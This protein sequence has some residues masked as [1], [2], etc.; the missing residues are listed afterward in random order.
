MKRYIYLIVIML[1][2]LGALHAG[3]HDNAGSYGYKFLNIPTNPVALALGS[4][5]IHVNADYAAFINQPAIGSVESH[6]TLGVAHTAWLDD[7]RYNTLFYS[8][9]DR[10][11]HFG[12]AMRN[13]DYGELEARDDTG[14]LIGYYSP[15]DMS[16]MGNYAYRLGPATYFGVNLGVMYQKL[17]TDSSYGVHADAG[18]TI[19]PPIKDSR[20]SMSL[21]NMGT[22]SAMNDI[23][24]PM[25][26]S[27]EIDFSKVYRFDES[28]LTIET[29]AV[30]VLDADWKG[31]V[32]AEMDILGKAQLRGAYKI[33]HDA[34]SI[35]AGIGIRI[36]SI[37]IDYGWAAFT[38]Q[39]ND[40]HSFGIGYR[41]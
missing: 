11:S 20:L 29:S 14:V 30:K 7:T 31:V 26:T 2:T 1:V 25:P 13:L 34:E 12:I 32:S 15:L 37:S 3:I 22:S 38:N 9:S 36:K 27:I 21:R 17:N 5:G 41:F 24:T 40:I 18:V 19:L 8:L 39:L 35:S 33:N 4:R 16:L 28:A 10:K 23:R 6:R